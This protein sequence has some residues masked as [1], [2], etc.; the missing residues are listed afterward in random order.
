MPDG[1]LARD[2]VLPPV[3]IRRPGWRAV[4]AAA[5]LAVLAGAAW[6]SEDWWT[7]GRFIETT[8][9][10]YVGGD[11]TSISPHVAGF[12]A[13]V[14]VGDNQP[15]KRGQVLIRL[16]S[17]DF[18]VA[19]ERARATLAEKEAAISSLESQL[20]LQQA[21]IRQAAAELRSRES[22]AAFAREHS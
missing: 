4:L 22:R 16:D 18:L 12:V 13:A 15:V 14:E 5:G 21:L 8:D 20:G 1:V 2:V 11:V 9:D 10:A 6:Y 19:L 17:K 3:A 7:R